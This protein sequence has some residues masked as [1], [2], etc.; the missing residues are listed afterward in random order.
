MWEHVK[1][2]ESDMS[3]AC[4]TMIN[5]TIIAVTDGSYDRE[6]AKDV[7]RLGWI[8]LCT[9]SRQTLHG[10][11]YKI[12]PIARSFREEFL[13]LAAIHTLALAVACFFHLDCMYGK[14]FCDNIVALNQSS[15][16]R[17]WVRV[18]IKHSDLH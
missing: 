2:E 4:N 1:D 12:S 3:W 8:L 13:G 9:A 6:R 10:S 18:G 15:K 11:F 5:G 14:I 17:Q 16:F 7:S